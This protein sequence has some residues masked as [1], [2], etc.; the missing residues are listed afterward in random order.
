MWQTTLSVNNKYRIFFNR[1]FLFRIIFSEAV[2]LSNYAKKKIR[3]RTFQSKKCLKCIST[4]IISV[5]RSH[6]I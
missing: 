4:T 1:T 5:H 2:I 6:Y 3:Q